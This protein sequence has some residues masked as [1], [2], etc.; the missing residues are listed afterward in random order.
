M[1]FLDSLRYGFDYLDDEKCKIFLFCFDLL[2][3]IYVTQGAFL[4][5]AMPGMQEQ[6][7]INKKTLY[8]TLIY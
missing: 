2:L 7:L 5:A 8:F 4:A 1:V 6:V 3:W